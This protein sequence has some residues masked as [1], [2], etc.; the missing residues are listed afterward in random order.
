ML[1]RHEV[2]GVDVAPVALVG[3]AHALLADEDVLAQRQR[4]LDLGVVSRR[5][6]LDHDR[7]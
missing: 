2:H 1:D 4:R 6:D 5:A 7:A 3:Q